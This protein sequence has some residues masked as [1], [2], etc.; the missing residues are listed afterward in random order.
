MPLTGKI[1]AFALVLAAPPLVFADFSAAIGG[2]ADFVFEKTQTAQSE[3]VSVGGA[4]S[5][6]SVEE[7]SVV[8]CFANFSV[9][10]PISLQKAA[11]GAAAEPVDLRAYDFIVQGGLCIGP[12]FRF[13]MGDVMRL[14]LGLGASVQGLVAAGSAANE[15]Y[16]DRQ[17]SVA[18]VNF[19]PAAALELTLEIAPPFYIAL[20]IAATYDFFNYSVVSAAAYNTRGWAE[21]YTMLSLRPYLCIGYHFDDPDFED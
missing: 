18:T 2:G 15:V 6:F 9:F 5:L 7:G 1:L 3:L 11:N 14:N 8:G 19:G 4:L 16:Q 20:G 13:D 17:F 12:G 21:D 10:F